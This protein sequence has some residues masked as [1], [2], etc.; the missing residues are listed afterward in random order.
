MLICLQVK[1]EKTQLWQSNIGMFIVKE[2]NQ[3]LHNYFKLNLKVKSNALIV[4]TCP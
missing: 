2:I 4:K 1:A 3:L